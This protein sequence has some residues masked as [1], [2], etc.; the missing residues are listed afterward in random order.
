MN[1]VTE[2]V[3]QWLRENGYDGLCFRNGGEEC[4]CHTD[5]LAPC[6]EPFPRDCVAAVKGPDGLFYPADGRPSE[7]T[8]DM[9]VNHENETDDR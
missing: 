1:T 7:Q 8:G 2:I 3:R 4:G 9:E 5:T 6:G